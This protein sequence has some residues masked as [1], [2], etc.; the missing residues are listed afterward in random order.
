MAARVKHVLFPDDGEP[1]T[2]LSRGPRNWKRTRRGIL[3]VLPCAWLLL[4]GTAQAVEVQVLHLKVSTAA[5]EQTLHGTLAATT[6]PVNETVAQVGGTATTTAANAVQQVDR[7]V[8]T[9]TAPRTVKTAPP[10]VAKPA[11]GSAAAPAAPAPSAARAGPPQAAN[12]VSAVRRDTRAGDKPAPG[13]RTWLRGARAPHR[14]RAAGRLRPSPRWSPQPRTHRRRLRT[15]PTSR[16]R[17]RFRPTSSSEVAPAPVPR[18]AR[19]PPSRCSS[20]SSP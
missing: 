18:A 13:Q 10:A 1:N 17:S 12:D 15:L 2:V 6:A 7:T 8:R 19:S 16:C 9:V 3:A 4:G 14:L 11:P 5:V 20:R